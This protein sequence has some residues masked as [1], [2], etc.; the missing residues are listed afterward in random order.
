[1]YV[2]PPLSSLC[3]ILFYIQSCCFRVDRSDIRRLP[4]TLAFARPGRRWLSLRAVLLL[5]Q[6]MMLALGVMNLSHALIGR[7]LP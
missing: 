7:P 2:S 6:D 3:F 1:M 5:L 4:G